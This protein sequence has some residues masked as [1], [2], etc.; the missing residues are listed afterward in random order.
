[1]ELPAEELVEEQPAPAEAEN[2]LL[3]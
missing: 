2:P 3:A 1:V